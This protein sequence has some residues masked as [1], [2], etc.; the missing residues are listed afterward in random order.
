[1][2]FE[3]LTERARD[4]MQRAQQIMAERQHTQ[5]DVE[6]LLLALLDQRD[7]LVPQ[8]LE[9][10]SVDLEIA[11]S[12][13]AVA[14]N[15]TPR[16]QTQGA[17][18]QQ[19]YIT[20]RLKRAFDSAEEEAAR[21]KDEYISTEHLLIAIASDRGGDGARIL[22]ELGVDSESIYR[23]LRDIRGSQRVTDPKAEEKYQALKRYSR[24]LT[25]A[26][27]SGKLDP[28]VGRDDEVRRVIQVLVRRTKNNPVLIGEPGVG[29]TAIVEGL[30]QKI[31][32]NDVP[33]M[34]EEKRVLALDMGALVAGSKFRGEFEE[35]LKTVM[36]EV[37]RAEGE[38]ILF[39]DELHT[40]VGA[41]AAEGA[42]DAS[43]MLKPALARG[44]LRCIGAT[45]LD[46]YRQHIEKD[47]ALERR[48]QP[49][50]VDEPSVDETIE[51]L[52]GLRDRYEAHHGI[53]I[54][55]EALV[56]AARLSA[57][58]ITDRFLPDKAIDLVDEAAAKVRV[59]LFSVPGPLKELGDRLSKLRAEEEAA[60][61][62]REY[63][64][65]A[66]LRQQ[67]VQLEG[68]Y[69]QKR[70]AWRHEKDIDE[71]V[72]EDDIAELVAA[73]TG[74]P[75]QRMVGDETQRLLEMEKHLHERVVGQDQAIEAVSDAIRRARAGLKD[76]RRPIGSFLFVGPTGVG[77]TLLARALAE[78][79]F[80]SDDAYF[81]V[82][83]SEYMERHAV[84]RLVGAPPGYVGYEEGGA[85]TEAVRRRPYQVVLFDEIEKAHPDAF[86]MLLQLL[87]DGRLTDGQGHTVDFRNTVVVMTSN[88]GTSHVQNRPLGFATPSRR[89]RDAL[90]DRVEDELK[91]TF[92][93]EFLNRIDE[94]IVFDPLSEEQIHAI[95]DQQLAEVQGR[96]DEQGIKIEL[97]EAA[98]DWLAR[99]G[100]DP[101]YGARPL[102]RTV[103]RQLENPLSKQLLRGDL[104]AGDTVAVDVVDGRP[105]FERRAAQPA[106]ESAAAG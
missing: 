32:A 51:I 91:K 36:E 94:V 97:T 14:L 57:R 61:A 45:T 11:R 18:T 9:R 103:Q 37:R 17:P 106:G 26:A 105:T 50:Y 92:R 59:D 53:K 44:E 28:V 82:D 77:K 86:N 96:L 70:D 62:A 102:R 16:A 43:N 93:P 21:L 22:R 39:I 100:Y 46:E 4:A 60:G 72:D 90:K 85:L 41:G 73:W 79:L 69:A 74:V 58:Y 12:R 15:A 88:V 75:V 7:G 27:R 2:R 54:A 81:R 64:R 98:R 1:V 23:A 80:G 20:P 52:R 68:E 99:E 101:V 49:V 56:A 76:P 47:A 63:E 65:A 25:E 10:L 5:L 71:S 48:F 24:D 42:I 84:S 19:V 31:V 29:K 66:E 95:V 34:L 55:D 30:A 38:I 13:V 40:V 89:E 35:R 33:E 83:M 67:V 6:H 78:Y 87:D 8:I 3:Q 104:K